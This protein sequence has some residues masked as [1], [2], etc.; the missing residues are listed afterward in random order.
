[1]SILKPGMVIKTKFQR[2]KVGIVLKIDRPH[3]SVVCLNSDSKIILI[4]TSYIQCLNQ[5]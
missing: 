4:N 1:M 3:C 5:E 2:L